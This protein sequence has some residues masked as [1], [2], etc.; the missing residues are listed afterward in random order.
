MIEH[1]D[2]LSPG[3]AA[4]KDTGPFGYCM[5]CYHPLDRCSHCDDKGAAEGR[6]RTVPSEEFDRAVTAIINGVAMSE[7]AG[8][9]DERVRLVLKGLLGEPAETRAVLPE[10]PALVKFGTGQPNG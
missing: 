10:S 2:P 9:A 6:S 1:S 8:Q 5:G 4:E 3:G 7:S